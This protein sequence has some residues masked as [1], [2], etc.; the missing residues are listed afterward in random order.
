MSN[1]PDRSAEFEKRFSIFTLNSTLTEQYSGITEQCN[2]ITEKYRGITEQ[3]S[4][5]TE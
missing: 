2:G 4:E 3:Y 1:V 5:I